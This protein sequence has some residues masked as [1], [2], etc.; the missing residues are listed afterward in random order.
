MVHILDIT[1]N[2]TEMGCNI[3]VNS[4]TLTT[5]VYLWVLYLWWIIPHCIVC[6][7]EPFVE[8][9]DILNVTKCT[10]RVTVNSNE[11]S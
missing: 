4:S 6:S 11:P 2:Y 10:D 3:V 9:M 7:D 8:T 5:V 1:Y